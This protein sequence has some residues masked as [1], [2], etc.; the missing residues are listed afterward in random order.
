MI[1]LEYND[2]QDGW[3]IKMERTPKFGEI[4]CDFEGLEDILTLDF[5]DNSADILRKT[6]HLHQ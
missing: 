6:G 2:S 1:L 3:N 4:S 5:R